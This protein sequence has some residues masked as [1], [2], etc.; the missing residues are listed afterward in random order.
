VKREDLEHIIRA[1]GAIA[2]SETIIILGSQAVLGLFPDAPGELLASQEVDVYPRDDPARADLIDGSIGELSPFHRQFG[3]YAHGVGPETATLP[4]NWERRLVAVRNE[5]TRG[6]TGLC[7][8]P[9]DIAVSKLL[10][11]RE[12]DIRFVRDLLTFELVPEQEIR[13]RF[14][15]LSESLAH[16]AAATLDRCR[17]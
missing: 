7:L 9:T 10:A 4:G 11:G 16:Q 17:R 15:E 5:N 6:V 12:K 14:Q 2:E 1:A 8:H 13:D 3:Y